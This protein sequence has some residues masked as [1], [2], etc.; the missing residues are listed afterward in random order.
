MTLQVSVRSNLYKDSVALMRIAEEV[1][2]ATGVARATLLMGTEANKAI[3]EQAGLFSDALRAARAAD[4]MVL[5]EDADDHDGSRVAAALQLAERLL[6]GKAAA[7]QPG[8]Q[9]MSP[10]SMSMAVA[11]AH[12]AGN[13]AGLAQISVPGA[14][15]AAEAL[16]AIKAG[17]DVFL[18]S[19]NVSLEQEL[20]IKQLA[21]A[22][23]RLVMGPDCGTAIV[24]GVPLGFANQVRRGRIGLVG[25]SGTGLQEVSCQIHALGEGVS[26]AL[27]TGGRDPSAA[28]G[29][30]SLYA[31]MEML[32]ADAST[33]VI[34][35]ISKPPAAPVVQGLNARMQQLAAQT[36]KHFV[37]L[38]L[39]ASPSAALPGITPVGTLFEAAAQAV[40]LLRGKG[41]AATATRAGAAESVNV[42]ALPN[43]LDNAQISA[44]HNPQYNPQQRYV[45]GLFSGGTFCTEAQAIW[46][47]H[48][49][50]CW[51]NVPLDKSLLLS[52]ARCS[53]EH[54]AV[55]LGDDVFTVGR[56][57]PM[58]DPQLRIERLLAEAADPTVAVILLDVVLGWGSH[59][60]PAGALAPAIR[61]AR[62]IASA[63]GR[64]L[65]VIGFVTGTADD[66]QNL[67]AQRECLLQA[68]VTL[69]DS[70]SAAAMMVLALL[71]QLAAAAPS[72]SALNLASGKAE[73]S[74]AVVS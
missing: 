21:Q 43:P 72:Q 41:K 50:R 11:A 44:Q 68:G 24:G 54:T 59:A 20:A 31:A 66:P 16:K 1:R 51:S 15:A 45:R 32:A 67:A 28:I 23:G 49:L 27:G 2:A 73:R 22:H 29:G 61:Q 34:V 47:A 52:D 26:H 7:S 70:S 57:H 42:A 53:Q 36:G 46:Q 6:A 33:E 40:A 18:F 74:K 35:L 25:A 39:G 56:P 8:V 12:E 38:F 60:D 14:Y 63:D 17:L 10:Q 30:I 58:I 4:L 65:S 48:G 69:A 62:A 3:L 71:A 64:A 37:V 19:D 55:D 9:Q 13:N 5:V